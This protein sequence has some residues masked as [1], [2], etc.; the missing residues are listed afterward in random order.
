MRTA[1]QAKAY[2]QLWGIYRELGE[3]ERH[4][5]NVQARYRALASTWLLAAMAGIG[6]V[7][8]ARGALGSE[9]EPLPIVWGLLRVMWS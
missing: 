7:L 8:E 9:R 5:G 4:F 1:L 2:E 3:M 6:F